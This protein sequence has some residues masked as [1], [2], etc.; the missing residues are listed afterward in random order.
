MRQTLEAAG[1]L[2]LQGNEGALNFE[3]TTFTTPVTAQA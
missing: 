2:P 1:F 3:L